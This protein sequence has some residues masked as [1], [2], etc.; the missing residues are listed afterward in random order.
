MRTYEANTDRTFLID[1][2]PIQRGSVRIIERGDQ[3]GLAEIGKGAPESPLFAPIHFTEWQ[4]GTITPYPTKQILLEDLE[5]GIFEASPSAS[6]IPEAPLDNTPYVREQGA[7]QSQYRWKAVA[8]TNIH[9]FNNVASWGALNGRWYFETQG[10][11]LQNAPFIVN[12]TAVYRVYIEAVLQGGNVTHRIWLRT[13]GDF[14]ENASSFIRSGQTIGSAITLGWRRFNQDPAKR[15]STTN[16]PAPISTT[17]QTFQTVFTHAFNVDASEAGGDY[18]IDFTAFWN[19]PSAAQA[20]EFRFVIDG[21]PSAETYEKEPKDPDDDQMDTTWF[22]MLAL[23]A[24]N[25]TVE[26]QFRKVN[27]GALVTVTTARI[28]SQRF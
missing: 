4:D 28:S 26:F 27:G 19:I 17:L 1:G 12:V 25:H 16:L 20:A 24:G 8:G 9:D 22:E 7:W 6:G 21:V 15:Y 3:I 11:N 23:A 5:S 13:I 14:T 18:R 2:L 10:I